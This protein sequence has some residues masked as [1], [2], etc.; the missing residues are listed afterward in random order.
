MNT[1]THLQDD[2]LAA[3]RSDA[4]A[5]FHS[6]LA[7]CNV[8]QA[9]ARHLEFDAKSM[10]RR[11]SAV[12]PPVEHS[13]A[14][15]KRV[16]VIAFGKAAVPMLDALLS[17]LP[18]RL[19]VDGICAAPV[20][21]EKRQKHIQYFAGSHPLPNE[22]SF[23]AARE[24]LALVRRADRHTL[25]FFLLSGGGSSI[26]ELPRDRSIP[27][28]D[29]RA[30][31]ETLVLSGAPIAEIN[32]V[33][34]FFSSIKGGQLAQAAPDAMRFTLLLADVPLKD[35][36]VVASSPTLPDTSTWAQCSAV[37]D[38]WD[39]L[40]RFP[41]SVRAYFQALAA[42]P[43]PAPT[44]QGLQN[45]EMD[46]LLSN[47]DFVNAARDQARALGYKVVIDNTCDEWPFDRA[48]AYLVER[49]RTL[50]AEWGRVCLLSSGEVT[51]Q[52]DRVRHGCGGRNQHFALK[53]ALLLDGFPGDVM[54]LSAGSDG[55]DGNSPAAGAT[56][57]PTTATRARAFHFDP[58][59]SLARFNS[60][61][62][63]T[64]LGD[65]IMTGPTGNNLRDL[66]IFLSDS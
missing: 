5:I 60:C 59:Q 39:L 42:Q 38:Q 57:D 66:R 47:H 53:T 14:G 31:Y 21:P 20:L 9:F 51:V 29:V 49:M 23:D 34:K 32:T 7:A 25:I 1:L 48:A 26:C 3:L 4:L 10:L 37:L 62:L 41:A 43:P 2:R 63:F 19:R 12:L 22:E 56:V 30:F 65:A 28:E 55:L 24:A 15:V 8:D 40:P 17:R 46:V 6:S 50:R 61:P 33:R 36:G 52:M 35:L 58:E 44:A 18:S 13:L 64:A 54:V 27:L 45:M 11:R 16:Q